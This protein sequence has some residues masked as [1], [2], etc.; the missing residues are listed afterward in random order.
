[1]VTPTAAPDPASALRPTADARRPR[2]GF[3]F[4]GATVLALTACGP[5]TGSPE[6]QEG[7]RTLEDA[8]GEVEVPERAERIVALDSLVIDTCVALGAPLVGAAEAGSVSTLPAYLG[9]GVEGV[10]TVG[11]IAEPNIEAIGALEPDLILG[12]ELRHEDLHEQLSAMAATFFVAEPAI[13]WQDNVLAIGRALGQDDRAEEVLGSLL[14]EAADAGQEVGAEGTTVH[15]LRH[16]DNGVRLHGPDTFSGSLLREM[17]FSVPD[18][19]WD[20]NDMAE[21]SFENLDRIDADVVFVTDDTDLDDELLSGVP[22]VAEGNA[23]GVDDRTWISG[24][25][26]VGAGHIIADVRGFLA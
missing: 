12:T 13:G 3:G 23:Y 19:D 11:N 7:G 2:R 21:L 5:G 24:I 15:V 10:E 6:E 14:A 1:M 20:D 25:G 18:M 9:E 22:A 26:V 17:G 16:V 8:T 4:A